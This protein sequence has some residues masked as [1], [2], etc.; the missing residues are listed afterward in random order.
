MHALKMALF[1][2][3]D[4]WVQ[5]SN[6]IIYSSPEEAVEGTKG[7]QLPSTKPVKNGI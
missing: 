7:V 2:D 1:L 4:K 6:D 5:L 3:H